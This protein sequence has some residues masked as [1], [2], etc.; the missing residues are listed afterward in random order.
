MT[1][2]LA[3]YCVLQQSKQVNTDVLVREL[4]NPHMHKQKTIQSALHHQ[5]PPDAALA[6]SRS[7]VAH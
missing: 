4:I 5:I 1:T 2:T 3:G 7:G 6:L